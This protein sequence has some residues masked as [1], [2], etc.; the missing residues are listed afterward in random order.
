MRS[1][2]ANKQKM[3]YSTPKDNRIYDSNGNKLID[4][5][6]D[7]IISHN[8]NEPEITETIYARDENGDIIYTDVDGELTPVPIETITGYDPPTIFHANI[9]F[10][11]GETQMAEYGLNVSGYDAVISAEKGKLLFNERTLIWHT[12]TPEVDNYGRAIKES[13]D[14]RVIAV[15]TSLNEERFILKKRVDD[16]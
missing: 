16:E 4:S 5:D 12:S 14:Y 15:K 11:S 6:G 8:P 10:N 9:S 2:D 13:A 3:W 7:Y 1:L